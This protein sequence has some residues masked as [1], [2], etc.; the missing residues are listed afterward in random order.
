MPRRR[1][2]RRTAELLGGTTQPRRARWKSGGRRGG[3]GRQRTRKPRRSWAQDR[4]RTSATDR[5]GKRSVATAAAAARPRAADAAG[6]TEDKDAALPSRAQQLRRISSYETARKLQ[7]ETP[8]IRSRASIGQAV[9]EI[10]E[11]WTGIP[12]GRMVSDEIR[13]C[14]TSK[15]RWNSASSASRT[16]WKPSRRR[17]APRAP[18]SPIRASRSACS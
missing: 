3:T 13:P 17:S 11:G 1:P 2:T 5:P 15:E 14:S 16:R 18:G 10:V 7:G 12:A 4:D 9:A 8:L 6:S